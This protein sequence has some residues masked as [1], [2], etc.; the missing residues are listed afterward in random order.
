VGAGSNFDHSH[1]IAMS[2]LTLLGTNVPAVI[3]TFS[4]GLL[5]MPNKRLIL[6]RSASQNASYQTQ[7]PHVMSKLLHRAQKTGLENLVKYSMKY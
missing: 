4:V 7:N 2:P 1:W 5:V 6:F 3:M